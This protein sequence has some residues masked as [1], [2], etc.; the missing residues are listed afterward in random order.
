M[1]SFTYMFFYRTGLLEE[2]GLYF[3]TVFL[4]CCS[5]D[6]IIKSMHVCLQLR[7]VRERDKKVR[8]DVI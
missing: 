5:W 6:S 7:E 8:R 4:L 3:C 1:E 2:L